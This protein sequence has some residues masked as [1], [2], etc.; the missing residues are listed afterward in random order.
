MRSPVATLESVT[1]SAGLVTAG[2]G[3]AQM[4]GVLRAKASLLAGLERS[5]VVEPG[6]RGAAAFAGI[7]AGHGDHQ[8][9]RDLAGQ[10]QAT[11]TRENL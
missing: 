9:T 3:W 5:S 2:G 8:L 1:G 4:D 11:T 10:M 7:A 6:V